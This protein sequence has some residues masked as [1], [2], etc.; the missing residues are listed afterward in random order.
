MW[1]RH[2]LLV[3]GVAAVHA[4]LMTVTAGLCQSA[5]GGG[6]AGPARQEEGALTGLLLLGGLLALLLCLYLAAA[7]SHDYSHSILC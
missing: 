2:L 7:C 1:L 3:C 4:G 6:A 5:A